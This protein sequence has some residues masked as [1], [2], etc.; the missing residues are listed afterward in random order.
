MD[1][2]L[3]SCFKAYDIRG[4]VPDE[5][6]P[7]LARDI[8]TAFQA[9]FAVKKVAVGRDIRVTGQEITEALIAGLLDMGVDVKMEV[10]MWGWM[11]K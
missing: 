1:A 5:L 2:A 11:R 9:V 6:N 7:G 4:K 10:R 3:P 8:G